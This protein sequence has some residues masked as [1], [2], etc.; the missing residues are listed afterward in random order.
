MKKKEAAIQLKKSDTLNVNFEKKL[1][2]KVQVIGVLVDHKPSKDKS[3][4]MDVPT[5]M[6]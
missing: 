6:E 5:K 3:V 2:C 1:I 4:D